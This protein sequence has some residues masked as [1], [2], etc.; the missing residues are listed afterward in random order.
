MKIFR[1]GFSKGVETTTIAVSFD[2]FGFEKLIVRKVE[3]FP[4]D[5]YTS[6]FD[7]GLAVVKI[8]ILN[9]AGGCSSGLEG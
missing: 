1:S 2:D 3:N 7:E 8:I 9:F 6:A 5:I 4:L